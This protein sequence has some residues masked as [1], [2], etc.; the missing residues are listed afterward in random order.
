MDPLIFSSVKQW[1][2]A[3]LQ[4]KSEQPKSDY[5]FPIS[6]NNM[7]YRAIIKMEKYM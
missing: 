5:F 3:L 1:D 4:P 7:V 6:P 2:H